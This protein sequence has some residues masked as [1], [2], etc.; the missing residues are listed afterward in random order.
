MNKKRIKS[1]I[2]AKIT[3]AQKIIFLFLKGNPLRFFKVSFKAL[4]Q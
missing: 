4:K 3:T 2:A 1:I